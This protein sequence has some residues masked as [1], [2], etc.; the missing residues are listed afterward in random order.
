P[1]MVLVDMTTSAP[2]LAVEIAQ[3]AG[4][5]GVHVLD[6]PVSGGDI[7]A[8]QGTL[9]IMVGGPADVM[10]A[11]QPC[12]DI[13]GSTVVRQGDHGAG[14]HTKMVNQILVASSMISMTEGLL[15]AS[16]V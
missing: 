13:M 4:D 5:T 12:F 15:Y 6:A 16:R 11:T 14:Q 7:G 8:R 2:S 10:D 3:V 9:S 1:D